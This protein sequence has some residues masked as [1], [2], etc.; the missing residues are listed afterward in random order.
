MSELGYLEERSDDSRDNQPFNT[1][2]S[3]VE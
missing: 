2:I 1:A 3:E